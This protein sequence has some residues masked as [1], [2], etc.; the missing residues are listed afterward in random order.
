MGGK[1]EV[2]SPTLTI[3]VVGYLNIGL[4]SYILNKIKDTKLGQ[5][6]IM[7]QLFHFFGSIFFYIKSYKN[8][9]S[10]YFYLLNFYT[11]AF[12]FNLDPYFSH[13]I[14]TGR[15]PYSN[16]KSVYT[17]K[18]NLYLP[19]KTFHTRKSD[20]PLYL[21]NQSYQIKTIPNYYILNKNKF[22][23]NNCRA[24]NRI[25]PH[26]LDVISIIFG[27]FLGDGYIQN[28]SGEGVRIYIK[29][30]IIHKEFLFSLYE[31]FFNRGYC[32]N[33]KPIKYT[34]IIKELDKHKYGYAF[35]TYTFRNLV[36]I[37]KQF[38]K[39]GK[40]IIPLN[41]EKYITPLSLAIWISA[42]G[43]WTGSGVR[44]SCNSFTLRDIGILVDKLRSKFNLDCTIEKIYM[45]NKYSIYI[46]PNSISNL[47]IL[48]LPHIHKSM[49]YKLGLV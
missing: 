24:I 15:D 6:N 8:I 34:I 41:I 21:S 31:F 45:K 32:N 4:K 3:K 47:R 29:Q 40:K 38:Y 42:D 46:K 7:L 35:N 39:K 36:W 37:Y 14:E 5:K 25:G 1:K 44:I 17:N 23:H 19:N 22:F 16:C 43:G 11:L 2:I 30:N 48:I 27:L 9:I 26:N 33:L 49:Y 13:R 12:K 20:Y 28:R 10:L 18:Y